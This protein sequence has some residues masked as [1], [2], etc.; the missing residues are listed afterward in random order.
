MTTTEATPGTTAGTATGTTT[1]TATTGTTTARGRTTRTR[2]PTPTPTP[3]TGAGMEMK[4]EHRPEL[5]LNLPFLRVQLRAPEMHLPHVGM[6]HISGRDVGHA[7]DVARTFLPPPERI[8]YYGGLGAL[9]A[10]GILEWP[11]AAAIGA[12]TMIAQRT[13][14]REQRWS[15]LGGPQKETRGTRTPGTADTGA[16]AMQEPATARAAG[17]RAGTAK[18]EAKTATPT[19]TT[20]RR[21]RAGA[22]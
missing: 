9:A 19:G 6:P 8:M 21:T 20:A 22:K 1:G 18:G 10:L 7:V 15:P 17:R 16:G 14:G 11:V 13:R 3:P 2:P 12:G 5:N 4:E